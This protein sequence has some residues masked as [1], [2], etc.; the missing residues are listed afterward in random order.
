MCG[1]QSASHLTPVTRQHGNYRK[2]YKLRIES[3]GNRT[4][5]SINLG[6]IKVNNYG[7][8]KVIH[9]DMNEIHMYYQ[10]YLIYIYISTQIIFIRYAIT[11]QSIEGSRYACQ[12]PLIDY[13]ELAELAACA[14]ERGLLK[15]K[16][17]NRKIRTASATKTNMLRKLKA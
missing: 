8:I 12:C 9:S 17:I 2:P 3:L 7:E 13:D 15:P 10:T 5:N 11:M 4:N 16:T 14:L 6:N 1:M